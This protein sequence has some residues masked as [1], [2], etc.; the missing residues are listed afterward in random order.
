MG[1]PE[2]L[3]KR[4]RAAL[5]GGGFIGP[6]HAEALRRIGVEVAGLLD[7]TPELARASAARIGVTKVYDTLDDLVADGSVDVVHIASPN[8]AHYAQAKRVLEA[9]K[10]VV[11]EKP[12]ATTSKETAELVALAKSRP[13]QAAAVNYNVRFYPLCHEM[14]DRVAR[15]DIGRV[16]SVTGSYTQDWLL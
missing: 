8:A 2:V 6:V 10:H 12:L 14:R 4:Y 5:V 13:K 11:C 15:G 16:L 1:A 7:L 9:G 3:P